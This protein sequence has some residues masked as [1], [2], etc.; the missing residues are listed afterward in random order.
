MARRRIRA[1][2]VIVV[3]LGGCADAAPPSAQP[4]TTPAEQPAQHPEPTAAADYT[5]PV[6]LFV[7]PDSI[8]I[9]RLRERL[10]D[11]AFYIT[12]DDANWYNAT[13]Y[14]L[15][16]SLQIANTDVDRGSASFLVDGEPRE[17]SWAE[18][19]EGWFLVVYDGTSM[20]VIS[21][22]VE[23]HDAVERIRRA[24]E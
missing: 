8:E 21:A 10:G 7:S 2:I 16:D 4:P 12:A 9:E 23:I 3:A 13:A 11:E 15:L 17:F 22:A 14:E 1:W 5:E 20:P 6:V 18:V 24:R 19:G